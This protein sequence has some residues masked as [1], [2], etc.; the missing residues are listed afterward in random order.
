M[1]K[2]KRCAGRCPEI[3]GMSAFQAIAHMIPPL[4]PTTVPSRFPFAISS[5]LLWLHVHMSKVHPLLS[6]H[7]ELACLCL[8]AINHYTRQKS[9]KYKLLAELARQP[10]SGIGMLARTTTITNRR[11]GF[12]PWFSH[13]IVLFTTACNLLARPAPPPLNHPAKNC[14]ARTYIL[15]ITQ[16]TQ[17]ACLTCPTHPTFALQYKR[18]AHTSSKI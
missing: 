18:S 2:Y 3:H 4:K 16:N 13:S 15:C 17:L 5:L 10:S 11:A 1:F 9:S 14:S 12:P 6:G 8:P 7:I